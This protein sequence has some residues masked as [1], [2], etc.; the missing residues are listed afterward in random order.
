MSSTISQPGKAL[1]AL[2][3]DERLLVGC[4]VLPHVD[5]EV[6]IARELSVALSAL[7]GRFLGG[8]FRVLW[9]IIV[10]VDGSMILVLMFV[11][12]LERRT[13]N[14]RHCTSRE[15]TEKRPLM[16]GYVIVAESF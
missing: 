8:Y 6:T 5:L 13:A 2:R 11:K 12:L 1:A 3:A 9:L 10:K 14:G 15:R 4:I 16:L 7:E